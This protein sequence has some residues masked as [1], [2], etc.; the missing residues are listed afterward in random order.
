MLRFHRRLTQLVLILYLCIVVGC[1]A[2][3]VGPLIGDREIN[4]HHG[5]ALARVTSVSAFRTTVDYQDE[6]GLYHSPRTGVLYPGGLGEGQRVW[7]DYSKKNPELVKVEG[8]TWKLALLPATSVFFVSSAL[9]ALILV[10][11]GRWRR[12]LERVVEV[13]ARG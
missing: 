5:R 11:L 1:F 2:L 13:T 6:S 3:V 12:A 4:E 9:F 10:A 7:V 8:R